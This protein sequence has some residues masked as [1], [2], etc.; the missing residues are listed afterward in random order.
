[1]VR[2]C[3]SLA[4]KISS[5]AMYITRLGVG[6]LLFRELYFCHVSAIYL[7][8]RMR[9]IAVVATGPMESEK[10]GARTAADVGECS[11]VTNVRRYRQR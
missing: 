7:V 8:I 1:M 4:S 5:W 9:H 3:W 6:G 10:V 11:L 2:E